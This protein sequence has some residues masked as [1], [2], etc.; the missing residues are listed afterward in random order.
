MKNLKKYDF[1]SNLFFGDNPSAL[2]AMALGSGMALPIDVWVKSWPMP[3]K[4]Q[5]TRIINS[6]RDVAWLDGECL[7]KQHGVWSVNPKT[8]E[9]QVDKPDYFRIDPNT[10]MEID[11]HDHYLEFIGKY[12]RAIQSVLPSAFV[13]VEPVPNEPAPVWGPEHHEENIVYAPHWYD[14]HS[15][16][17][18]S[19]DGRIT[20]DVQGLSKV[21]AYMHGNTAKDGY[22]YDINILASFPKNCPGKER[23]RSNLLWFEWSQEKLQGTALKYSQ[24]WPAERW[25]QALPYWRVWH[26]NGHQPEGGVPEWRLPIPLQVLGCCVVIS[27]GKS[28]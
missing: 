28:P 20:H 7:W 25:K 4:K 2:E 19:F 27:G 9:P 5:R 16:F 21:C 23:L 14:L 13:F 26:S 8:G 1:N 15:L 17:N 3:T 12:S 22:E 18:K 11:F 10:G 24:H 6:E